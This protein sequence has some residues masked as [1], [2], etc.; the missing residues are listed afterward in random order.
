MPA[1]TDIYLEDSIPDDPEGLS[2][3]AVVDLPCLWVL[4][5]SS[6]V[7]A[8]TTVLRHWHIPLPQ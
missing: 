7:G 8:L 5:I 4:N 6:G 1:L 3:Y 2:T